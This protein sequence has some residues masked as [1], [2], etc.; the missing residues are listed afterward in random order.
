MRIIDWL[1]LTQPTMCP[2]SELNHDLLVLGWISSTEPCQLGLSYI[3]DSRPETSW[4]AATYLRAYPGFSLTSWGKDQPLREGNGGSWLFYGGHYP[5]T[6]FLSQPL[7]WDF[8]T[9]ISLFPFSSL[10]SSLFCSLSII[11]FFLPL[12]LQ[13]LVA[14]SFLELKIHLID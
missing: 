7:C 3:P 13:L 14:L 4:Y 5:S 10:I 6:S 9:L 1:P 12:T 2:E 11:H 8:Q